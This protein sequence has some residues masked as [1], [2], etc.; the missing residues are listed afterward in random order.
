MKR[1]RMLSLGFVGLLCTNLSAEPLMITHL[2]GKVENVHQHPLKLLTK[3]NTGQTISLANGAVVTLTSL[4]D[5]TRYTITGQ[6]K[7]KVEKEGVALL[8][9]EESKLQKQDGRNISGEK[10]K[11][12]SSSMGGQLLRTGEPTPRILSVKT[13]SEPVL[14]WQEFDGALRYE[15]TIL[16][17]GKVVRRIE[18]EGVSAPLHL[19]KSVPYQVKLAAIVESRPSVL[20]DSVSEEEAIET[21]TTVTLLSR[22]P[23]SI[24]SLAKDK[25]SE[26]YSDTQDMTDIAI[27]FSQLFDRELYYDA[28]QMLDNAEY[29]E[30]DIGELRARLMNAINKAQTGSVDSAP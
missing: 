1:N 22:A 7:A 5:G 21:T 10:P 4:Q 26:L 23:E 15:V 25:E 14:H 30:K 11:D 17:R 24:L 16:R 19:K 27:V 13:L 9:G 18:T 20:G 28:L 2:E 3:V 6:S 12:I 29:H 8:E